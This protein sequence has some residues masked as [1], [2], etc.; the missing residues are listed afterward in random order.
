MPLSTD[1][2]IDL[3]CQKLLQ[4]ET[5]KAHLIFGSRKDHIDPAK[6]LERTIQADKGFL[7][8]LE[9]LCN[10]Y[11][12]SLKNP[13]Y[14][15]LS[16]FLLTDG[17]WSSPERK[18]NARVGR[19]LQTGSL[20]STTAIEVLQLHT[21]IENRV[22]Q[23]TKDLEF[24]RNNNNSVT[25]PG[26]EGVPLAFAEMVLIG[27]SIFSSSK[28]E[29]EKFRAFLEGEDGLKKILSNSNFNEK[30]VNLM[31]QKGHKNISTWR[32][33]KKEA[34]EDRLSKCKNIC[35]DDNTTNRRRNI[36][37]VR[38]HIESEASKL[39]E[40]WQTFF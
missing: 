19:L 17:E 15:E 4:N 21:Q 12:F 32:K 14:T 22:Q 7:K 25:P 40:K 24:I 18:R 36:K 6:G 29:K 8:D 37:T 2:K 10:K 30:I 9:D 3:W 16:D 13:V 26:P 23:S 28:E 11:S 31:L 27:I 33:S 34:F 5:L 39:K 35:P 38:Q 1:E 20:S